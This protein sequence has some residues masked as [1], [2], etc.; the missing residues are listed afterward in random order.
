[1]EVWRTAL[2]GLQLP[3]ASV[4]GE[5]PSQPLGHYVKVALPRFPLARIARRIGEGDEQQAVI[6]LGDGDGAERLLQ[7][8][9]R[10]AGKLADL[11][12][13]NGGRLLAGTGEWAPEL[14]AGA[15][16]SGRDRRGPTLGEV[17]TVDEVI[18]RIGAG[19]RPVGEQ[20]TL[21]RGVCR[22]LTM[23]AVSRQGYTCFS[24]I[25]GPPVGSAA[26][27]LSMLILRRGPVSTRSNVL[28]HSERSDAHD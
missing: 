2:L 17:W 24:F 28:C 15:A 9:A 16:Y 23:S 13:A 26:F 12:A 21:D 19:G 25:R 3:H 7:P 6:D 10:A 22:G 14:Y 4:G 1:M 18:P 8:S 11:T 5:L 20:R 27:V